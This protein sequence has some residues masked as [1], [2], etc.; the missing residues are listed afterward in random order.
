MPGKQ[1][2]AL[3]EKNPA[4]KRNKTQEKTLA[5]G[6]SNLPEIS[7]EQ[8]VDEASQSDT[9]NIDAAM[10]APQPDMA[11]APVEN[12]FDMSKLPLETRQLFKQVARDAALKEALNEQTQGPEMATSE[13]ERPL[14]FGQEFKARAKMGL[15]R[16]PQEQA[17]LLT[18]ALGKDFE[19]KVNNNKVVFKKK[20]SRKYFPIDQEGFSS[21]LREL[22]M[23]IGPD[24]SGEVLEA[25]LSIGTEA[26]GGLMAGPAGA[27]AG[28]PVGAALSIKARDAAIR[29]FE[30][31]VSTEFAP[32]FALTVGLNAATL[33]LGSLLKGVARKGL[34]PLREI[35]EE[36]PKNRIN[37]LA[38]VRQSFEELASS[39]GA[40]NLTAVD[41]G[42][43]VYDAITKTHDNLNAK[44]NLLSDEVYA[45]AGDQKFPVEALIK[46]MDEVLKR[47]TGITAEQIPTYYNAKN[48]NQL[49][50]RLR[51]SKT[52]G[53]D[54][55]ADFIDMM[56]KQRAFIEKSGGLTP[57]QMD[58]YYRFWREPSL[59][60]PGKE[61]LPVHGDVEA[62]IS[63]RMLGGLA[64][65]RL[66]TVTK[67]FADDPSKAAYLNSIRSD[68]GKNIEAITDFKKIFRT[69]LST[70]RFTDALVQPKS[71]EQI[72]TL[73]NL[74]GTDSDEFN[75][76]KAQWLD[77]MMTKSI[78]NSTGIVKGK[79][80]LDQLKHYGD[81][82]VAELL[83][84]RERATLKEIAHR[85]EA[86]P[87]ADMLSEQGKKSLVQDVAAISAGYS[88]PA[89][90]SRL[91]WYLTRGNADAAQYLA[92]D[93]LLKVAL[94]TKDPLKKTKLI[95]VIQ[96]FEKLLDSTD[97]YKKGGKAL[98][99]RD[100]DEA[101]RDP[102]IQRIF[103]KTTQRIENTPS[104]MRVPGAL[105]L[106][107]AQIEK[108]IGRPRG[109]AGEG[110]G[111]GIEENSE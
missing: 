47:E 94:N 109:Q 4:I 9:A 92:R 76:I 13:D 74:L 110:N 66:G 63:R 72:K 84:P 78:D 103:Q 23:D 16:N 88:H 98:K 28:I 102:E 30:G 26:A 56:I 20:G 70:E 73:K 17:S 96:G 55:G 101:L 91:V 107:A 49:I 34:K 81:D 12:T 14:E 97:L 77:N 39:T 75:Y 38:E 50:N 80:L 33:G 64:Q 22:A 21:G 37:A 62:A 57:K 40:R 15:G 10:P 1:P 67:L 87:F 59:L 3:P 51:E 65:D 27:L 32:E 45:K 31:D 8:P 105:S 90:I 11:E 86:I 29:D 95:Q 71:S 6:L 104:Q 89:V 44:M 53:S 46:N 18:K 24:I 100:F 43:E 106:P 93:G 41:R 5:E 111:A 48:R 2:G 68:Y 108:D 54:Q 25:G 99:I 7:K 36:S 61:K 58:N 52:L 83:S 19:V 42:K 35:L 69:K 85:A 82:T 79:V 60:T